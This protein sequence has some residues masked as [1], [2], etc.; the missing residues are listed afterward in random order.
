MGHSPSAV[1]EAGS[2]VS[3]YELRNS[4]RVG[5]RFDMLLVTGKGCGEGLIGIGKELL[6]Y[7][8]VMV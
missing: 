7:K 6:R 8:D 2:M 3:R 1:A 5:T 4:A